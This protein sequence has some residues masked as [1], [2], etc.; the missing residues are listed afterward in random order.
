M[1]VMKMIRYGLCPY[2]ESHGMVTTMK[3]IG[4]GLE[5]HGLCHVCG[6]TCDSDYAPAEESSDLPQEFSQPVDA[7][8]AD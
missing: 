6:Y 7:L 5:V 2:C 4:G 8:A 1:E 3:V